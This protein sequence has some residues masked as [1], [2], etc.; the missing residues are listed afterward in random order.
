VVVGATRFF[1]FMVVLVSVDG[2]AVTVTLG[3]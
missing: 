3:G 1:V 2:G